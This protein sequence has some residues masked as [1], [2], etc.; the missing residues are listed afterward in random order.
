MAN[1]KPKTELVKAD[2]NPQAETGIL[3]SISSAMG[4]CGEAIMGGAVYCATGVLNGAI[5]CLGLFVT[6]GPV[7]KRA[8]EIYSGIAENIDK[9]TYHLLT[10][11]QKKDDKDED[12]DKEK[13]KPK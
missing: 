5:N 6:H 7:V 3:D 12:K 13:P 1:D 8:A 4:S 2:T 11:G 10:L 9:G